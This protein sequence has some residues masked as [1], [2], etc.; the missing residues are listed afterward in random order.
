M[1]FQPSS[2][3]PHYIYRKVFLWPNKDSISWT[4]IDYTFQDWNDK[5]FVTW[6]SVL[7]RL[8]SIW[9]N[10]LLFC[11][12]EHV[13]Y[14]KNENLLTLFHKHVNLCLAQHKWRKLF[15]IYS[16]SQK[17]KNVYLWPLPPVQWPGTGTR[18]ESILILLWCQVGGGI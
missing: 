12:S 4:N 9:I 13:L 1:C 14:L 17:E 7:C 16:H 11:F 6:F 8:V 3:F 10:Y 18:K 5:Y 2:C 15:D